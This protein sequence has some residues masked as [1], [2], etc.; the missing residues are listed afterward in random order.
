[1]YHKKQGMF[2]AHVVFSDDFSDFMLNNAYDAYS[3]QVNVDSIDSAVLVY[4]LLVM[5]YAI[6]H[7]CIIDGHQYEQPPRVDQQMT[8]KLIDDE[9][10]LYDSC[11]W[12]I[13][14][15]SV[16]IL[17]EVASAISNSALSMF[18][19]LSYV[20][21]M[22]SACTLSDPSKWYKFANILALICT[23]GIISY[24]TKSTVFAGLVLLIFHTILGI[25]YYV[26]NAEHNMTLYKFIHIRL[27][28]IV[29]TNICVS[30]LYSTSI[31][32][33]L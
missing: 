18:I 1:M 9:L 27:W 14:A 5:C 20:F 2:D 30:A 22:C 33:V 10:M 4:S 3:L 19:A 25:L 11:F 23:A 13:L 26:H 31:E 24:C 28:C 12:V 29:C 15:I 16:Y 7:Y 6:L 32:Q 17:V 8:T 21:L